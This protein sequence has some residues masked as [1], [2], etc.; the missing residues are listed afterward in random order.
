[1]DPSAPGWYPDPYG[2]HERRHWS[3]IRWSRHVEDGG[4][5]STD[6]LGEGP[7]D[8]ASVLGAEPPPH[9]HR[10]R[11]S[12]GPAGFV[13]AGVAVVSL[14]AAAFVLFRQS[15][16][17]TVD[18]V[19][20]GEPLVAAVVDALQQRSG[21]SLTD[22]EASCMADG[23]VGSVGADR[24]IDL[25]VLDGADPMLA[26]DE[27]EKEFAFPK[28]FD[29]LDDAAM[30]EFMS[31]TIWDREEAEGLSPEVAPCAIRRWLDGLGR[32]RVIY[33]YTTFVRPVPTPINESLNDN[34]SEL[35]ATALNECVG[36]AY[37]STGAG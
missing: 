7:S 18:P 35:V 33:L 3:G 22:A 24:L 12:R 5:R 2:R 14:G 11:R 23:L 32:Q 16:D 10:A 26:I 25:R 13:A 1:M 17:D 29:C 27:P 31:S 30:V 8:P 34:E 21:G 20:E 37:T 36:A 4:W 19:T 9:R 6:P 15:D 28:A